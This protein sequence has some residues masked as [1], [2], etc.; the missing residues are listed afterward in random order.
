MCVCVCVCVCVCTCALK[1][2]DVCVCVCVCVCA[3]VRACVHMRTQGLGHAADH[4]PDGASHM[5]GFLHI[6]SVKCCGVVA[7]PQQASFS[8]SPPS[9][10]LQQAG[11][12]ITCRASHSRPE[13]RPEGRVAQG[14]PVA[15][16]C[17]VNGCTARNHAVHDPAARRCAEKC[18]TAPRCAG[19]YPATQGTARRVQRRAQSRDS[20]LAEGGAQDHAVLYYIIS[21]YIITYHIPLLILCHQVED[22]VADARLD[23][24]PLD[25]DDVGEGRH[26]QQHRRHEEDLYIYIYIIYI[27]LYSWS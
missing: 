4:S 22:G 18:S 11:R 21:Y 15:Q 7:T 6:R 8:P 13:G 1:D 25:H 10:P 24:P 26:R 20:R 2:S 12:G 27:I 9:S 19:K 3:C 17:T 5:P 23:V 14:R 16:P